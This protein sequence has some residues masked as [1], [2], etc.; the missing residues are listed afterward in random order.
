M[1]LKF[2][3]V[4]IKRKLLFLHEKTGICFA[5]KKYSIYR[6]SSSQNDRTIFADAECTDWKVLDYF[7]PVITKIF[8][9]TFVVWNAKFFAVKKIIY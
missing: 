3:S 9:P 6:D 4:C 7:G 1:D 2:F 8:I 5:A